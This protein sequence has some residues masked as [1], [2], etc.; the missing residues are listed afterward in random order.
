MK[1]RS[2]VLKSLHFMYWALWAVSI[3]GLLQAWIGRPLNLLLCATTQEDVECEWVTSV[4]MWIFG[5]SFV[6]VILLTSAMLIRAGVRRKWNL[7]EIVVAL[8]GWAA[9]LYFVTNL[10]S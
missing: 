6:A 2:V 1:L 10:R 8:I 9:L 7:A 4:G 5:C 3:F